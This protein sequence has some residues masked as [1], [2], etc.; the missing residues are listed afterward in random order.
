VRTREF[1]IDRENEEDAEREARR[2]DPAEVGRRK[3]LDH[4]KLRRMVSYADTSACLRATILRYFGDAAAKEPCGSCGNCSRLQP[5]GDD[6]RLLVRKILS[7]VARAGERYGRRK[8]AAMLAG[9]VADLP[10]I[11]VGLST[12]G[13]LREMP[14]AMVER[15]IDV[16]TAA[17]LLSP[18]DDKYRT[19]SL[20]AVGRDVMTGRVQDVLIAAPRDKP[21]P[22]ARKKSRQTRADAAPLSE[23]QQPIVDAL[24][25]W[26]LDEARRN[27]IAPFV[28]LHDRTLIAIASELPGSPG[29]LSSIPGIGPAKLASYGDAILNIVKGSR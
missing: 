18:S 28:V 13:L 10:E 21:A 16:A 8:I 26:R 29:E 27:A 6:D 12:T 20:T 2:P 25:A 17:G 5:I 11:L 24:R 7:G 9:E 19:L 3:E 1:L 14:V 23:P 4:K 22:S 15:W